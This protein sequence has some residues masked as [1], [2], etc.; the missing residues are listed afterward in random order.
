MYFRGSLYLLDAGPKAGPANS[1]LQGGFPGDTSE[2]E[3]ESYIARDRA[4]H[5][6]K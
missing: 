6:S 3:G 4:G 1:T 2:V 5:W